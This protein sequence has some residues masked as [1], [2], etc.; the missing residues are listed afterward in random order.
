[1][2]WFDSPSDARRLRDQVVLSFLLRR[3][4]SGLVWCKEVAARGHGG[5]GHIS[6]SDIHGGMKRP[7][8]GFSRH[9]FHGAHEFF[10]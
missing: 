3:G 5:I 10:F 8:E 9:C 4:Y 6:L 2:T 1:M 7:L